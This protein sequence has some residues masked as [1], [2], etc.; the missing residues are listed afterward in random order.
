[1]KLMNTTDTIFRSVV[2]SGAMNKPV[3]A[4]FG[5]RDCGPCKMMKARLEALTED[6]PEVWFVELD[7]MNNNPI[8]VDYGVRTAPTILAFQGG[9]VRNTWVGVVRS[10]DLHEDIETTFKLGVSA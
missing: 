7:A 8:F 9:K 10:Q 5:M 2:A 1:M 4:L 6:F 3:I